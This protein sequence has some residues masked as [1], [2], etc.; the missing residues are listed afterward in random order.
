[1]NATE[2]VPLYSVR[3]STLSLWKVKARTAEVE[4]QFEDWTLIFDAKM[5]GLE[6]PHSCTAIFLCFLFN[7]AFDSN[8]SQ[9]NH[10]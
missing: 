9:V 2:L 5:E 3:G 7:T 4:M 8:N 10:C 6:F 1:M